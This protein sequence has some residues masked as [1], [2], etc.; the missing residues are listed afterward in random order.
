[1]NTAKLVN[2]ALTG[3]GL[4]YPENLNVIIGNESKGYPK[5]YVLD[6]NA[7]LSLAGQVSSGSGSQTPGQQGGNSSNISSN[8][9]KYIKPSQVLYSVDNT[10]NKSYTT[11]LNSNIS[12]F[13]RDVKGQLPNNSENVFII[14]NF[15]IV[16]DMPIN[17]MLSLARPN[18]KLEVSNIDN[19]INIF[20]FKFSNPY[21]TA[22]VCN[23][24][25]I[26]K[27]YQKVMFDIQSGK[28]KL[29][30]QD[31]AIPP[32]KEYY[33]N[34]E[35]KS[36][37]LKEIEYIIWLYKW[38]SPYEAY[39]EK[40]RQSVVGK[41]MFNDDKYKPT[42]EMMILAKRFQ[43]FQQTPGTRLLSS[44]QSAAEGLIETLN[45]YSEGSMDIDT[46]LKIT[47]ILKDVSGV[48]KSLDIAMK[49]AKAEQLESGKVKGGGVIGL[50]ETVK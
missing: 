50:Y 23:D 33:N 1:M 39:P 14:S 6:A 16:K 42:A 24:V 37:A 25:H 4:I 18:C 40:E 31:L 32:F 48:V 35:D 47:R 9:D 30:T 46:A 20:D 41:D 34:A 7:T 38:N 15:D 27:N 26:G 3:G 10:G 12:D 36:Q 28:I 45:Q 8:L 17:I 49:Q 29:S 5:G 11:Q 2:S 44:S 22:A 21:I 43:E 13:I 19:N